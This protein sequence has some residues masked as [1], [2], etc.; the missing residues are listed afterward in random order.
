ME[1]PA[2]LRAYLP[3]WPNKCCFAKV[4]CGKRTDEN[5]ELLW[6]FAP[7]KELCILP[8]A[9]ASCSPS[10]TNSTP[11]LGIGHQIALKRRLKQ[12]S[13]LAAAELATQPQGLG[14]MGKLA[15]WGEMGGNWGNDEYRW[16]ICSL[17]LAAGRSVLISAPCG[18]STSS[19]ATQIVPQWQHT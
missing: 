4:L 6:H 14:K 8:I 9:L 3:A 12:A 2:R 16:S 11:T 17:M 10:M 15:K 13:A 18:P 7:T 19:N 1:G 5:R